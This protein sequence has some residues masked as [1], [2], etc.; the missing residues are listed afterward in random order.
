MRDLQLYLRALAEKGLDWFHVTMRITV[1]RQ[2][3]K[4]LT[5]A[6]PDHDLAPLDGELQRV[7]WYL[8][9][10]NV[11]GALQV[12]EHVQWQLED[13]DE[14][15]PES[16]KLTKTVAEFHSY[17]TANEGFIP[18]YGE[19]YRYGEVI[20][21]AFVESTVK[22]VIS[23]RMVKKQQMRF[24]QARRASAA[25]G[26]GAG[27]ERGPAPNLRALVTSD[28]QHRRSVSA[29]R[30]APGLKWSQRDL[31]RRLPE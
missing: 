22:E 10:G 8:W 21:T 28:G 14:D 1:L 12:I 3:L 30:V 15:V 20:S 24:S 27:A 6:A 2:Q 16:R 11:L 23:K 29:G 26:Q 4:E 13:L 5:A 19:R 9:H 17:I 25:A 18:N 7:K 31:N